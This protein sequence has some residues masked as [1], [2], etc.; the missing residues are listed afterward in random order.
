MEVE[1]E[2]GLEE[3]I[4][5]LQQVGLNEEFKLTTKE[6]TLHRFQMRENIRYV[7]THQ[8]EVNAERRAELLWRVKQA[9]ECIV[10][11]DETRKEEFIVNAIAYFYDM[12]PYPGD[13][14][15]EE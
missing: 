13:G 5:Q 9:K 10:Q 15:M 12:I 2:R 14:A 7:E 4:A 8:H 6:I 3:L 1:A 11:Y